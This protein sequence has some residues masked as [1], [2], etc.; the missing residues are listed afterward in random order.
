MA[1]ENQKEEDDSTEEARPTRGGG[2]TL[3]IAF[4]SMVVLLETG[5]FFFLVPSAEQVSALAEAKLIKS[6]QE[7]EAAA[8]EQALDENV[9]KEFELGMYGET[10]SPNHTERVYRVEIELFG[11]CRKKNLEKMKTE[12]EEKEGRLRHEIRMKIRNSDLSELEENNLGL[13]QRRILTTCNHLLEDDLLLSVG[14]KS[15]QLIEQ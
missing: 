15:Y 2:R 7:G 12:Y 8:E 5:M 6:V 3:I 4:V 13:L 1:D 11:T 9:V 14:F 10:F